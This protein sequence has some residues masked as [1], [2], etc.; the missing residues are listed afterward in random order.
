MKTPVEVRT[1]AE[2]RAIRIALSDPTVRAFVLVMGA[3]LPLPSKRAQ[4]RVLEYV[5]DRVV[6]L[7]ERVP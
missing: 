1:K 3:L 6:E 4:A 2:G 7:T 5:A